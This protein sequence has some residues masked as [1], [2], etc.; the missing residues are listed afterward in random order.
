MRHQTLLALAVVLSASS[1]APAFTIT[2][3]FVNSAAQTWTTNEE[4]VVNEAISDWTSVLSYTNPNQNINMEFLFISAGLNVSVGPPPTGYLG[5]WTGQY[6]APQ[7]AVVDPWSTTMT[8]IVDVN[9]DWM[10]PPAGDPVLTF[11]TGNPGPISTTVVSPSAYDALTVFRHEIG[12]ALG[13]TTL[14]TTDALPQPQVSPSILLSQ[15]TDAG[16]TGAI[17]DD[18]PGGLNIPLASASNPSHVADNNDLMSVTLSNGVSKG[19]GFTDIEELSLAY[20]YAITIPAGLS[21]PTTTFKTQ[22]ITL[23]GAVHVSST[24]G[25]RNTP[26]TVLSSQNLTINAGGLLDLSNHDLIISG[27]QTLASVRALVTAGQ[28]NGSWNGGVECVHLR[29]LGGEPHRH[30]REIHLPRRCHAQWHRRSERP[31]HRAEQ[32]GHD[33][34]QLVRGKF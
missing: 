20:G 15:V 2:P 34:Q 18:T 31:R 30:P 14:Y 25:T 8:H 4:A 16:P 13:L 23:N 7:N 1:F 28:G 6:A 11:A 22:T 27:G 9:T 19:I 5:L 3:T 10:T 12:H 33:Q 32:P 17:F 21:Y 26:T 24:T 29:W